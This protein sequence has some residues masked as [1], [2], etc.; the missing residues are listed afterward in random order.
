MKSLAL[1]TGRGN[2]MAI[3]LKLDQN[4]QTEN[5]SNIE[6]FL[7]K[8]MYTGRSENLSKTKETQAERLS[9]P[10]TGVPDRL[11][12]HLVM[13]RSYSGK[14]AWEPVWST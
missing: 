5:I 8:H 13:G 7:K 10:R 12:R 4:L 2:P 11:W 3:S 6:H 1:V 14:G 9:N